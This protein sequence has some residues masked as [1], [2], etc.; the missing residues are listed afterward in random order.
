MIAIW[1]MHRHAMVDL[2]VE[3]VGKKA[4]ESAGTARVMN[5]EGAAGRQ[6]PARICSLASD[7][8]C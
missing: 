2:M 6:T 3:L 5:L 4:I 1:L 7:A 8:H